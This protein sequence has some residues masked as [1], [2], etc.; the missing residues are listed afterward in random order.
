MCMDSF[1]P[2][3]TCDLEAQNEASP[4][5][6][7]CNV[8]GGQNQKQKK[9]KAKEQH[10]PMVDSG[11]NTDITFEPKITD[12][13]TVWKELKTYE[14]TFKNNKTGEIETRTKERSNYAAWLGD[15]EHR[16]DCQ[17]RIGEL[18]DQEL[19]RYVTAKAQAEYLRT[20]FPEAVPPKNPNGTPPNDH[21]ISTVFE[22]LY[23][24]QPQFSAVYLKDVFPNP[25]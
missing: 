15:T 9:Q 13:A 4:L 17:K 21:T 18:N 3:P 10:P 7:N 2:H 14:I 12:L 16:L 19:Q 20:R 24:T 5:L 6:V 1:P 23:H 8:S 25:Y 11:I 22:I